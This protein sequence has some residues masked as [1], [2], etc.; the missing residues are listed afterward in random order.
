MRIITRAE[1]G[2]RSPK[3]TP[4][5]V[6]PSSRAFFVLHHSGGPVDQ[7]VRA[8][9]DW[10]M[11]GRGFND[12]D[13]NHLV[14]GSTGEI[15]EGR[16]WDIEGAHTVGF[17]RSGVGV[18]IIGTDVASEAARTAV[19]WLNDQYNARCGLRLLRRG[20]RDLDPPR[21]CPGDHNE[22]WMLA[23]MPVA[24]PLPAP[25]P[26]GKDDIVTNLPTLKNG[27][28]SYQ[29]RC[30]QGL[31]NV[32]PRNYALRVDGV[33]GDRTEQAVRNEQR[34]HLLAVDGIAGHDTW[35]MLLAVKP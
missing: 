11:D 27:A 23:G 4:I 33:F 2:A 30:L 14:R 10:C 17:N 6:P 3:R 18:C 7:T 28:S 24:N 22:A 34:L 26:A 20:H 29:V 35:S 5:Y 31:L 19:R 32:T 9:Q 13:Y 15:Y 12:I 25:V 16:G 1:W 8:I 21:T